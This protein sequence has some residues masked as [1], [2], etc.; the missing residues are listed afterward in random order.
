MD[1][2]YDRYLPKKE[3]IESKHDP[4][5]SIKP[6]KYSRCKPQQH[7]HWNNNAMEQAL[8]RITIR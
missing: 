8:N 4:K 1:T 5:R 3:D 2:M 6:I 7:D